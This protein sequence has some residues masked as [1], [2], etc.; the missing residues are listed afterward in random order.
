MPD[1]ALTAID[2]EGDTFEFKAVADTLVKLIDAAEPPLSIALL[3]AWGSGK[4]S[5]VN[6]VIGRLRTQA[7][8]QSS[9]PQ[10]LHLSPP[11]PRDVVLYIDAWKYEADSLRRQLL[12]ELER[13]LKSDGMLAR[14][15]EGVAPRLYQEASTTESELPKLRWARAPLAI[16]FLA[17]L[18]LSSVAMVVLGPQPLD[19][20]GLALLQLAGGATLYLLF[21]GSELFRRMTSTV[22][23]G[24]LVSPEQFESEFARFLEP[25]VVRRLVLILDNIDRMAPEAAIRTLSTMTTYLEPGSLQKGIF[26][27]PLDDSALRAHLRERF[28]ANYEGNDEF[29]ETYAREYLRKFFGATV[30]VPPLS[31]GELVT[32][33]EAKLLDI[34][35]LAE[36]PEATRS[37]VAQL[38]ADVPATTPRT[39]KRHINALSAR[40][41]VLAARSEAGQIRMKTETSAVLCLAMLTII[42]EEW[43][44]LFKDLAERPTVLREMHADM[45]Q[46]G[47][48]EHRDPMNGVLRER[49]SAGSAGRFIN[50][51]LRRV[52]LDDVRTLIRLKLDATESRIEDY[53]GFVDD[54]QQGGWERVA[55]RVK[56]LGL[57]QRRAH[58]DVA[59][60]VMDQQLTDKRFDTANSIGASI[61]QARTAWGGDL[62][63]RLTDAAERYARQRELREYLLSGVSPAASVWL[64]AH[65]AGSDRGHLLLQIGRHLESVMR[66]AAGREGLP[67]GSAEQVLLVLAVAG[68]IAEMPER[69][70]PGELQLI[71]GVLQ[72]LP[73]DR[74]DL[75]FLWND[76]S[77]ARLLVDDAFID[78]R[79]TNVFADPTLELDPPSQL[80]EPLFALR[81]D[82]TRDL[83]YTHLVAEIGKW[84]AR[85]TPADAF[86]PA[87][88]RLS[89]AN[90][91]LP[92]LYGELLSS[93][94]ATL[95][96][97]W[98]VS[99]DPLTKLTLAA[100]LL[101]LRANA[102][103]DATADRAVEQWAATLPLTSLQSLIDQSKAGVSTLGRDLLLGS[104]IARGASDATPAAEL[105]GLVELSWPLAREDGPAAELD[106]AGLW[107]PKAADRVAE[108][109]QNVIQALAHAPDGT[110]R[111]ESRL[112]EQLEIEPTPDAILTLL[113]ALPT[114]SEK[115]RNGLRTRLH[116]QLATRPRRASG[117]RVLAKVSR[118]LGDQD[119]T[120]LWSQIVEETRDQLQALLR[121]G[122]DWS[123]ASEELDL[124]H[125]HRNEI[126]REGRDELA[127]VLQVG[128]GS[129]QTLVRRD[130]LA[131]AR[132]LLGGRAGAVLDAYAER[133]D[134][135]ATPEEVADLVGAA[136]ELGVSSPVLW[137]LGELKEVD[138]DGGRIAAEA[139]R[140]LV[141]PAETSSRAEVHKD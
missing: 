69:F 79:I 113:E 134:R 44:D 53:Q 109:T 7:K 74:S 139:H 96:Q 133:L 85:R 9:L 29:P 37:R 35:P 52:D 100:E 128:A 38:I 117:E 137:K 102:P 136:D 65:A 59:F 129:D 58:L 10:R 63:E 106:I 30:R 18:W 3:G 77:V 119:R 28:P 132:Q 25:N 88:K 24:P 123:T 1:R 108:R 54:L 34:K 12:I 89:V 124:L 98:L 19:R 115:N 130:S 15:T 80:L 8:V 13:Q 61:L 95:Q 72:T 93:Y 56:D 83:L 23:Q 50:N 47:G 27:V 62:E 140:R 14:D 104:V 39:A 16:G 75:G 81:A 66:P 49:L 138:S 67:S 73:L 94:R 46:L 41:A 4:T 141:P 110:E 112:L 42:E 22:K 116:A 82:R 120:D 31:A 48:A 87:L 111:F 2:A 103:A 101:R 20:I 118:L 90:W 97:A 86:A 11:A 107:L 5:L 122:H 92:E 76:P 70:D 68:S 26:I 105:P 131:R 32:F 60:R 99:T 43:P 84:L 78:H 40:L 64:A 121:E 33:V 135:A 36:L 55:S 71:R 6:D 126:P 114:L 57:E 91:P 127:R 17:A 45:L 51:A 21:T 125:R